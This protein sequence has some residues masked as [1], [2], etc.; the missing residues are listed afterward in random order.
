MA[1]SD[2]NSIVVVGSSNADMIISVDRLPLP[3]ETVIGG[4][5]SVAGGGKGANQAMAAARLGGVVTFVAR[6]GTDAIGFEAL[7]HFRGEGI[8]VDYITQD[9]DK[10]SGVAFILVGGDG[11]NSIAV[12]SGAN[13][14]LTAAEVQTAGRAFTEAEILLVQLECPLEAI[15]A[16]VEL[17]VQNEMRVILNPAPARP[18]PGELLSRV[19]LLTPNE[20]EA[21]LLC[22]IHVKDKA[23]AAKAAEALMK[24]GPRNAI[25]TLGAKGAVIAC[26]GRIEVVPGM[27]VPVRDTT[28]AGDVFNGALAVALCEGLSIPAAA[29]FA[30]AAAALSVSRLG[31][32]K[33]APTRAEIE[34]FIVNQA[35]QGAVATEG[36]VKPDGHEQNSI[37][38]TSKRSTIAGK[39]NAKSS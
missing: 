27:K 17:A 8:N 28:G 25:V 20:V 22:G 19:W 15:E 36:P 16:A 29:R 33:S 10:P 18:L 38:G 34:E 12:A 21:E 31:A 9:K 35:M 26:D 6:L 4:K 5:F 30:N 14:N 39:S 24:L 3:G 32:Q 11:Q 1:N 23:G 37:R 7:E 13:A 2:S